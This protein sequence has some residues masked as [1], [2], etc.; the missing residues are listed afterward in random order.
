MVSVLEKWYQHRTYDN[1]DDNV[2]QWGSWAIYHLV[3]TDPDSKAHWLSAGAERVLGCIAARW[4]DASSYA[5][6]YATGAMSEL[7]CNEHQQR[8]ADSADTL[9]V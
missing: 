5:K 7:G 9:F 3:T 4:S 1:S 8:P 2:A 6:S